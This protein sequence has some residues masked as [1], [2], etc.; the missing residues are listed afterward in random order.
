MVCPLF[1]FS[2]ELNYKIVRRVVSRVVRKVVVVMCKLD[3]KRMSD[4]LPV[5]G[6]KCLISDGELMA[7]AEFKTGHL[8][9]GW[10]PW[11]PHGFGGYEWE[12]DVFNPFYDDSKEQLGSVW[13][14]P[15]PDPPVTDNSA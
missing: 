9:K 11:G 2:P 8:D 14:A 13:W 15:L 12:F 5:D 6:Q 1:Q 4:A 7:T 10:C 3:W